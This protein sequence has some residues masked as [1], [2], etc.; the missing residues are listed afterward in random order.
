[1]L[2][3]TIMLLLFFCL[4]TTN[5]KVEPK[6]SVFKISTRELQYGPEPWQTCTNVFPHYTDNVDS[7]IMI[8]IH[9][10][11]WVSGD[12]SE[13]LSKVK[14][15]VMKT[16]FPALNINYK[17]SD[18]NQQILDIETAIAFSKLQTCSNGTYFLY[19]YS[20]G[21]HLA[22]LTAAL[23]QETGLVGVVG[24]GAPL[25]LED[26]VDYC[27][28]FDEQPPPPEVVTNNLIPTMGEDWLDYS[29]TNLALGP[30]YTPTLLLHGTEDFI[31]PT[32]VND[33]F[34]DEI[35]PDAR[36]KE[37]PGNHL[38]LDKEDTEFSEFFKYFLA[39]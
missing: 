10:G 4:L 33:C 11:G 9:G 28:A 19:G 1:M 29:L 25:C 6:V 7:P 3:K 23:T 36:L 22:A 35:A 13:I 17:L 38:L 12:K 14:D 2:K 24:V 26:W 37:L 15:F 16:G 32:A 30:Y 21:G 27:D 20:A 34:V 5:T 18:I 31:V 8:F 39:G